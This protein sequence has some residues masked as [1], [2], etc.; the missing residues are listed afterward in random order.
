MRKVSVR[1]WE[2]LIAALGLVAVSL[3][4]GVAHAGVEQI[5]NGSFQAPGVE[6][7]TPNDWIA[8]N[9]FNESGPYDANIST[10]DVDGQYPGPT[11]TPG[12]DVAGNFSTEAFY[13]AGNDTGVEGF[14]GS[15]SLT[16]ASSGDPQLSWS[17]AETDAPDPSV[18]NWAGSAVE[19]DFTSGS[20][21]YNLIFVNPFTSSGGAYSLSPTSSDTSTTQYVVLSTL[22]DNT[23]Y[24]QTPVDVPSYVL[25]QFGLSSFTIN[26]VDFENLED[27]SS[28]GYPYPNMD[29]Y[30]KNISLQTSAV[31]EPGSIG[32]LSV[33][34]VGLM[35]RRSGRKRSQK[36]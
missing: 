11:G 7:A 9:F 1:S 19:V 23:W 26:S 17:T 18:A 24:T 6:G 16:V 13:E 34:S 30:W 27:T 22:T 31:P 12:G 3:T 36:I 8:T 21:S 10:Y 5:T 20:N 28:S 29:S 25:S 2:V 32:L 14:G 35:A 15:Q 4:A 33:A